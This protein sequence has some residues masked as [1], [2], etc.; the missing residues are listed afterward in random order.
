EV[1]REIALTREAIDPTLDR[2]DAMIE[3]A[4]STGRKASEGAVTG[5]FSGILAAPFRILGGIGSSLAGLTREEA[6]HFS[7]EELAEYA[8]MGSAI[9][10]TGEQGESIEWG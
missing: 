4:R 3:R 10:E 6:K 1:I 8:R 7:E 2:L 9:L 5:V